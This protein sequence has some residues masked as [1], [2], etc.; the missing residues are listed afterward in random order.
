MCSGCTFGTF[1]YPCTVIIKPQSFYP[2][3]R[4]SNELM[5]WAEVFRIL[6]T[7]GIFYRCVRHLFTAG[8]IYKLII[9]IYRGGHACQAN[10]AY[11]QLHAVRV[12]GD[13]QFCFRRALYLFEIDILTA[14]AHGITDSFRCTIFLIKAMFFL[15]FCSWQLDSLFRDYVILNYCCDCAYKL[16]CD[17][18]F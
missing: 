15:S 11:I 8:K 2:L 9:Y 3:W 10:S 5:V 17:L 13:G 1:E 6:L 12:H 16:F 18:L 4:W 7:V 14:A